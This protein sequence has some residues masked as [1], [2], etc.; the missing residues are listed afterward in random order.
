MGY[1]H[2]LSRHAGE[3]TVSDD[4]QSRPFQLSPT[5]DADS[6]LQ[7]ARQ[8]F[9]PSSPIR[10]FGD[11]KGRNESLELVKSILTTP[12][13]SP[14]IYGDRGVGKTSLAHTAAWSH[15]DSSSQPA[16]VACDEWSRFGPVILD[17]YTKLCGVDPT[18]NTEKSGFTFSM[19]GLIGGNS[20]RTR[21]MPP[22]E[23]ISPSSAITLI[24]HAES[25]IPAQKHPVVVVDE[26]DQLIDRKTK[27]QFSSFIKQLGDQECRTKF[28][29]VGIGRNITE[30]IESH[31]SISRNI[32][33]VRLE[34]LSITA[35][36]EIVSSGFDSLG[37][38]VFQPYARRIAFLSDG[39]PH[40]VH[41]IS[42]HLAEQV[43]QRKDGVGKVTPE[44]IRNA[45]QQSVL[46]SEHW[47]REAYDKATKQRDLD[48]EPI[49]WS[50]ADHW[51]LTR[52][53]EEIYESYERIMDSDSVEG[54]A[55]S[56][57]KFSS[58]LQRLKKSQHGEV[59]E[60]PQSRWYRF[61]KSMLRGYCRM[62]A[63]SKGVPVGLDYMAP[64][65][66]L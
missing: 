66:P 25:L 61:R 13:R 15:H 41:L 56:R 17:A 48:Y 30:F 35:L 31:E 3:S 40:F 50:I 42:L 1:D 24:R 46:E 14:F 65:E 60:S 55:L 38:Q 53:Y 52:K 21:A 4:E 37:V 8:S 12:G 36:E 18:I 39:F 59:I 49:L 22:P 10:S 29:F 7:K 11:L 9:L 28:I 47:L 63:E 33:T 54:T 44:T 43:I 32:G 57:T 16:L 6:L 2:E 19:K 5:E 26:M 62:V 23:N 51:Q 20:E 45:L 64:R 34:R 58:A 27:G